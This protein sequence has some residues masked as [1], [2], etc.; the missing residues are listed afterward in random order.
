M[1][2]FGTNISKIWLRRNSRRLAWRSSE[3]GNHDEWVFPLL[4]QGVSGAMRYDDERSRT[5]RL[6]IL[7]DAHRTLARQHVDNLVDAIVHVPRNPLAHLQQADCLERLARQN[8]FLQW[9]A[10]D[11]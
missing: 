10:T 9:L 2:F 7:V 8:R 5:E 4:I 6:C 11:E 1:A 3:G